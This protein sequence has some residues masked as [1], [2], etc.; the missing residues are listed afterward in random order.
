MLL[1]GVLPTVARRCVWSRNL[2][3]GGYSPLKGCK[4]KPTMGCDAERKK[5]VNYIVLDGLLSINSTNKTLFGTA[6][7]LYWN[8]SLETTGRSGGQYNFPAVMNLK[9]R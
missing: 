3:R 4:Y 5:N 6:W 1:I 7:K 8:M 2:E 9:I